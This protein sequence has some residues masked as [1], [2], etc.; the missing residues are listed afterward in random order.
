MTNKMYLPK[1][2]KVILSAGATGDNLDKAAKLLEIVSGMKAQIIAAGSRRRI[3]AFGVRPGLPLGTRTT[4]RSRKAIDSLKK[5]LGAI[6]NQLMKR[7]VSDN[8]FSFGIKEYIEIPGME[9]V[10]EIGIRGFNVTVV[11]E[12]S[13][14]RVKRKK[15]KRGKFPKRQHVLKK[16][17]VKYMEDNFATKFV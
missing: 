17:I 10:R 1:I 2:K 13:G 3:P 6:D 4:L 5:L 16:E 8:H 7:Q 11:F 12:R 9:Y 15:I 14:M